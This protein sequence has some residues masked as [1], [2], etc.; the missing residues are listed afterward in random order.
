MSMFDADAKSLTFLKTEGYL[1]IPFFQRRYVWTQDNWEELF[2]NLYNEENPGFLGSIILK[3]K[4]REHGTK[5]ISSVI[6]GQQRLTTLSLF[7]VALYD[8]LKEEDKINK[9]PLLEDTL[10]N[11]DHV[12]QVS[13]NRIYIPKIKHSQLDKPS[14]EKMMDFDN[15]NK[16]T[17]ISTDDK[18]IKCYNYFYNKLIESDYDKRIKLFDTLVDSNVEIMVVIGIDNNADE[19]KVFDTLNSAGVRLTMADTIKNYLFNR[20]AKLFG[21]N[22]T[23]NEEIDNE[24]TTLY[25][26][27][28]KAT[29]NINDEI[30][31]IW[32]NEIVTGRIK[33][34][35]I[36]MLLHCYATIK[37]MYSSLSDNLSDLTIVYKRYIDNIMTIQELN[38]F[39]KDLCKYGDLYYKYLLDKD[40][41]YLYG[42]DNSDILPRLLLLE[43]VTNI[44]TLNPYI[45]YLIS[46][47]ENNSQKLNEELHK[48]EKVLLYSRLASDTTRT[49]NYNKLCVE[50]MA[51]GR[52]DKEIADIGSVDEAIEGLKKVDNSFGKLLLF[53][54]E[55]YRRKDNLADINK[56]EYCDSYQLEHIMPQKWETYWTIL[57]E[58][59]LD[60]IIL[61]SVEQK[62][63]FRNKMIKYLGN[64]TILKSK[65]NNSISNSTIDRKIDGDENIRGIRGLADFYITKND[66]VD[67]YDKYHD[68]NE[69]IIFSR[70][71]SLFEEIKEAYL[72]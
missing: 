43:R 41:D 46:K 38:E 11:F 48:V 4:P 7:I 59:D 58:T 63:D 15:N 6:D 5:P 37:E 36:D 14:F 40:E 10:Y 25:N 70:T 50:F 71:K 21:E 49:K 22:G 19:Q 17:N 44:K 13:G 56:L 53:L 52:I 55:I 18:I 24:I 8:G 35:N 31:K 61:E 57:P 68:W 47:Y 9:K 3:E 29:F 23:E 60:G 34:T 69:E 65:L 1:E 20:A 28:W 26:S 51:D 42:Y 16:I 30:D 72:Y 54:V 12:D 64:M 39:L 62:K 45:L 32:S 66:V 67:Y 2:D 27:T 33:R